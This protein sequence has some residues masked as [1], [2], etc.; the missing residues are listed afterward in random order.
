MDYFGNLD[1]HEL[2]F[3]TQ[4]FWGGP[5]SL[6]DLD[7]GIKN[8]Q[9]ILNGKFKSAG[10]SGRARLLWFRLAQLKSRPTGRANFVI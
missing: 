5:N 7:R 8:L 1:W 10:V 4:L 3:F 9:R 2:V 6:P